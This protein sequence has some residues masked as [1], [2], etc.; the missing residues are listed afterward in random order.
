MKSLLNFLLIHFII[1]LT[2]Q[3][4]S[5]LEAVKYPELMTV[6]SVCTTSSLLKQF[7]DL[8]GTFCKSLQ[9]SAS[10]PFLASSMQPQVL[11]FWDKKVVGAIWFKIP[12][13]GVAPASH[14]PHWLGAG[15][16]ESLK[17]GAVAPLSLEV[18]IHCFKLGKLVP[19]IQ[20]FILFFFFFFPDT[21]YKKPLQNLT[22]LSGVSNQAE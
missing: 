18:E 12:S 10:L 17:L 9:E 3:R 8:A 2:K 5:T 4:C 16:Q 15:T 11:L 19:A 13:F 22:L 7:L 14:L 21:L 20:K 1:Y 6:C